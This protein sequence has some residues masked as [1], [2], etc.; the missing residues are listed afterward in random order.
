VYAIADCLIRP[1]TSTA[2]VLV[3]FL[4]HCSPITNHLDQVDIRHVVRVIM[5]VWMVAIGCYMVLNCP[6]NTFVHA[7]RVFK[8]FLASATAVILGHPNVGLTFCVSEFG[9]IVDSSTFAQFVAM[10]RRIRESVQAAPD[11]LNMFARSAFVKRNHFRCWFS[12][13]LHTDFWRIASPLAGRSRSSRWSASV[14]QSWL[15]L[16]MV[17]LAAS[18]PASTLS[19]RFGW[20]QDGHAN[21]VTD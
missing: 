9:S 16:A 1:A 3:E 21:R 17:T 18:I 13:F 2:A 4:R 12:V 14:S 11:T 7:V 15:H 8:R 5:K 6:P 10:W 19:S 20:G